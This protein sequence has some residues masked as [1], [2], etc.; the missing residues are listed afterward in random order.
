MNWKYFAVALVAVLL[1]WKIDSLGD[2][3]E[4]EKQAHEATRVTLRQAVE[5]GEGWKAAY[6]KALEAAEAHKET[7][8]ACMERE[9]QARRDRQ[10]REAILQPAKPRQRTEQEQQQV[11]DD[12]TRK[13]AADR[14]NRPL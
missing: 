1:L 14:L 3:L 4:Q 7:A 11:I 9:L 2:D 12:E 8:A 5:D 13:R 6:E 10:E